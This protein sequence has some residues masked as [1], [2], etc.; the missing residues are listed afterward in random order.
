MRDM[1]DEAPASTNRAPRAW[2]TGGL[3][4]V[5]GFVLVAVGVIGAVALWRE[6]SSSGFGDPDYS[7]VE[8]WL[9]VLGALTLSALG[10]VVVGVG[11]IIER[12]DDRSGR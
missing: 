9:A 12:M 5:V 7:T 11:A 4:G 6:M 1:T 2:T 10:L 3:L 8:T